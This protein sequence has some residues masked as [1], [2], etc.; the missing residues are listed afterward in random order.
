MYLED[1]PEFFLC[2]LNAVIICGVESIPF[3]PRTEERREGGGRAG[4]RIVEGILSELSES[5][6]RINNASLS[7][8]MDEGQILQAS[9][10]RLLQGCSWQKM[11]ISGKENVG[12]K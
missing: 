11:R 3:C 9:F 2:Q 6:T 8:R 12:E 5:L 4:H 7:E 1:A 10:A